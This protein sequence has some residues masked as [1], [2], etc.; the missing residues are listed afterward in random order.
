MKSYSMPFLS[1]NVNYFQYIFKIINIYLKYFLL[2]LQIKFNFVF[3]ELSVHLYDKPV[4]KLLLIR[5]VF[6]A[7]N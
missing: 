5:N 7:K 6:S 2:F 3:G 4:I 1:K